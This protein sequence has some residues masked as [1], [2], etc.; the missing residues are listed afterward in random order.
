MAATEK[1]AEEAIDG[2][3]PEKEWKGRMKP[4]VAWGRDNNSPEDQYR[5]QRL[6]ARLERLARLLDTPAGSPETDDA[7]GEAELSTP[8]LTSQADAII[9]SIEAISRR[10]EQIEQANAG[11]TLV[12]F[13]AS[14]Q[15]E[16]ETIDTER[17]ALERSTVSTPAVTADGPDTPVSLEEARREKLEA[18]VRQ[19]EEKLAGQPRV[20]ATPSRA[21][22]PVPGKGSA[23]S[24]VWKVA[25]RTVKVAQVRMRAPRE[26][27]RR[28][29]EQRPKIMARPVVSNSRERLTANAQSAGS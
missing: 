28:D 25:E 20:K 19:R 22:I 18:E 1:R 23:P 15:F 11:E 2:W 8:D 14:D 7:A 13:E 24:R 26:S 5:Q 9:D 16:Q 27:E 4:S 6:S 3:V 10:D 21:A 29:G 17:D 12:P